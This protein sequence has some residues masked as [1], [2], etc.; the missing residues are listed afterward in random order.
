MSRRRQSAFMNANLKCVC[1]PE[2]WKVSPLCIGRETA[3][4]FYCGYELRLF[5]R[6]YVRFFGQFPFAEPIA[7]P[8]RFFGVV[9]CRIGL[10]MRA[11]LSKSCPEETAM[12]MLMPTLHS[13]LPTV[14]GSATRR[15]MR[16]ATNSA[17]SRL[18]QGSRMM[19]N[20]SPPT[21]SLGYRRAPGAGSCLSLVGLLLR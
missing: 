14:I 18:P 3:S 15:R 20:S 6:S 9:H 7:V 17:R 8:R 4:K 2:R 19:A 13:R 12:R 5:P 16:W 11:V 1:S 21:R 10:L